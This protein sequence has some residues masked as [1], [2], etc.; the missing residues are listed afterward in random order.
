MFFL[1]GKGIFLVRELQQLLEKLESD[2]RKCAATS[3]PTA[4]IVQRCVCVC[5]CVYVCVCMHV[6]VYVCVCVCVCMCV[7]VCVCVCV[8]MCVCVCV[9]VCMHVCVCVCVCAC[10]YM[11]ALH[12]R[13]ISNPLLLEGRKFDIRVYLLIIA[14]QLFVVLYHPGYIRLSCLP[15]DPSS[16]DMCVHLTNQYQQKKHPS[17][18][19]VK[20][21]TVSCTRLS[22]PGMSEFILLMTGLGL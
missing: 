2:K 15:Y 22:V 17:Y 4:R 10:V 6:C 7:C 20:E 13:Y 5:V 16:P 1:Q 8:C 14:A 3:Q 12:S 9:C 19:D 11:C 21:D 18:S